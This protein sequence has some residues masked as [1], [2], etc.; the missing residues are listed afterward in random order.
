MADRPDRGTTRSAGDDETRRSG[1]D[2]QRRGLDRV[3]PPDPTRPRRGDVQGK[4]ALYSVDTE[5]NPTSLVV[6]DCP[7]CEISR[8]LTLPELPGLLRP[9]WLLN[10]CGRRLW[11][12]CP[13]CGD[14]TWL[15]IHRGP[16]IPWPL[17]DATG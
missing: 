2:G 13:T 6:V 16:G 7:E 5:S 15:D 11:T 8:G 17:R 1:A 3:R 9:P 4:R 14:R 12:Q 10:P